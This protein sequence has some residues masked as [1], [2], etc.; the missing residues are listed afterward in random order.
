[1]HL[2]RRMDARLSVTNRMRTLV[3]ERPILCAIGAGAIGAALGGLLFGRAAR[4]VFMGM[5]GYLA[6]DLLNED[7]RRRILAKLELG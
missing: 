3:L 5:L 6:N 4:L 1:M 2:E 7:G